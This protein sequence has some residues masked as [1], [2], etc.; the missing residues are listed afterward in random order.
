MIIFK[1][2]FVRNDGLSISEIVEVSIWE[3]YEHLMAFFTIVL[4][5]FFV[6]KV[7]FDGPQ[8]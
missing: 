1:V 3:E 4:S 2:A 7:F 5:D 8:N 6:G